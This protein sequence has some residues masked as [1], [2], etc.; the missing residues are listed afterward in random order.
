MRLINTDTLVIEEFGFGQIPNYAILSHRW[1]NYELNLQDVQNRIWEKQGFTNEN[2]IKAF[3]KINRCCIRAKSDTFQYAWIDSCCIDKTSSAELSEA[4]NSMYLWYYKAGRCYAYLSDVQSMNT[5][6]ESEWFKRGWTLQE[7]LAPAEVFF[8]DKDWNDLGTKKS[9][10]EA[11]SDQTRIPVNILSGADLETATVAQRMSWASRRKT[12]RIEDSAYCLMGIFGINMPLLYGEGE[13]AFIRLQEEIMKI[14]NDHSIFA[15]KS[16]DTRGGLLATSPDAFSDSDNIIHYSPFGDPRAPLTVSSRGIHSALRFIGLG[17]G[18]F[19]M[20]ILHCA[21]R[22]KTTKPLAIYVRDTALTMELFERVC[23][24]TFESIDFHDFQRGRY[25]IRQMCIRMGRMGPIGR[26]E[27]SG[28]QHSITSDIND[29]N[30]LSKL[31]NSIDIDE[32]FC[33]A[34]T[35]ERDIVWLWLTRSDITADLAD[36]QGRT[37]LWY[38]VMGRHEALVQMLLARSDVNADFQDNEGQRP[39]SWAAQ[40]GHEAIVKLLLEKEV[41]IEARY[42][43][44]TPLLWAAANNHETITKMLLEIGAEIEAGDS[45]G[46]TSLSF[47]AAD[48]F[49]A[50]VKLLL[51]KGAKI[52]TRDIS[53][54][55]TPLTWAVLN[56]HEGIVRLLLENGA[57][58]EAGD[59]YR[60]TPLSLAAK[61]GHEAVVK[62]LLEN[63]A[64]MEARDGNKCTPLLQAT[65]KGHEAIVRLLLEKGADIEATDYYMATPLF[66]AAHRKREGVVKLLLENGADTEA[67]NND[68]QTPLFVAGMKNHEDIVKLLLEHGADIEAKDKEGQTV[69]SWAMRTRAYHIVQLLDGKY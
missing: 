53:D 47:T 41:D 33:A 44:Q 5:F 24:E 46:R 63:G 2:K 55:R 57:D 21:R 26:S 60:R 15:W 42:K 54:G 69:R 22:D 8:L 19:G 4:I 59:N 32:L 12:T 51:E 50:V 56:G 29:H 20:A 52:E 14:S 28:N 25:P 10:Q 65:M 58:I 18:G 43:Y 36:D 1:Y 27:S 30:S 48:G 40:H 11:V 38:A 45:D 39:L 34:Q 16:R 64:D 23:S 35:G 9:L 68:G 37:V 17:R 66:H 6:K 3:E 49:E 62:L 67:K 7:L 61:G 13:R 31:I